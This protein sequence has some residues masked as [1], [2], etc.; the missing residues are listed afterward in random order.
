MAI[1]LSLCVCMVRQRVHSCTQHV[2]ADGMLRHQGARDAVRDKSKAIMHF[3][4]DRC[5]ASVGPL[6]SKVV[7]S[8]TLRSLAKSRKA[9]SDATTQIVGRRVRRSLDVAPTH[10]SRELRYSVFQEANRCVTFCYNSCNSVSHFC[11]SVSHCCNSVSHCCY[12]FRH[13]AGRV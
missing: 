8:D 13:N 2:F 7:L 11:N 12:T 4:A 5:N 9:L 6:S 10:L 1:E 3:C